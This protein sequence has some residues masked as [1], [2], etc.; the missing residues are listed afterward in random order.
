MSFSLIDDD[1]GAVPVLAVSKAGLSAWHEAAPA[2]ERDWVMATGFT[3][4]GGKLALVPNKA[5]GLGRVLIGMVEGEAAMWAF[6]G[7]SDTLPE[8]SYRVETIPEGAD[9][10]RI[11][12]GWA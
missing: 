5:G 10:S 11:A 12:L 6:A 1:A 7:L 3:G 8:G 9:A 2:R 4:E